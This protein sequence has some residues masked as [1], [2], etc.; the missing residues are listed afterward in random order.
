MKKMLVIVLALALL[1]T[2]AI[3]T[4]LSYF[5]DDDFNTNTMTVGNVEIEQH[6]VFVANS[7][8]L[9]YNGDPTKAE[10]ESDIT[11]DPAKNAVVK[12]VTVENTGS[13]AAYIRTL[14]AFEGV[15][16][17][18][19]N[20][21]IDPVAHAEGTAPIIHVDHNDDKVG[22]WAYMGSVKID[23]VDYFVY[24]FTYKAAVPAPVAGAQDNTASTTAPSLKAI[25]L[26]C[27]QGNAFFDAVGA[28]YNILVL[29]QAVQV[30]GFAPAENATA[31]EQA[32]AIAAAFTAAF[33]LD[34]DSE[35]NATVI[36][37]TWFE[38]TQG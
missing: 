10:A 25:A 1:C 11:F 6:E 4:T 9:P 14:F 26:D 17:E 38:Q 16:V 8:L 32:A 28:D 27:D 34:K 36:P 22:T 21:Y 24:S 23:A 31:E 5:T 37:A 13:E 15:K 29:S 12:T 19:S 3:G 7:S 33:P 2:L 20:T 30:T 18:N 35:D